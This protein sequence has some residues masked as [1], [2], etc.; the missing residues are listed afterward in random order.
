[1]S[2]SVTLS[3]QINERTTA[4]LLFTVVDENDEGVVPSTLTLTLMTLDEEIV[5]GRDAVN[6]LNANGGT[7][8]GEGNGV[9]LLSVADTALMD[10]D[11][12]HESRVA[13]FEWTWTGGKQDSKEVHFTLRNVRGVP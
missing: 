5:N 13:L 10:Q 11:N 3:R 9:F 2:K 1:M 6:I 8:D 7:V 4:E 12:R